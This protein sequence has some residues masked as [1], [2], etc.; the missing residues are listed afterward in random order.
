MALPAAL[1]KEV[2]PLPV[3][4]WILAIGGGLGVS[5]WLS[6]RA[7]SKPDDEVETEFAA[8]GVDPYQLAAMGRT[9]GALVAL[10]GTVSAAPSRSDDMTNSNWLRSMVSN[11]SSNGYSAYA[12]DIA[13]RT[14]LQ[15]D[16]LTADMQAIV[17]KA[18]MAGGIPPEGLPPLIPAETPVQ[19]TPGSSVNNQPGSAG[20]T[21][22]NFITAGTESYEDIARRAY[23]DSTKAA[24][25]IA[26][27]LGRF[28]GSP[29]NLPKNSDVLVPCVVDGVNYC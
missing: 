22:G 11:L 18:L 2:G 19:T 1:T 3:G 10:P 8:D 16:A 14:Y 27:N 29:N 25:I 13:L 24:A 23:G 20:Q 21:H 9:Q 15:G 6:S 4:I 12:V 26:A 7:K 17:E 28:P 5:L